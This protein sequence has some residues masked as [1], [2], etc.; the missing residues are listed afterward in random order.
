LPPDG[1]DFDVRGTTCVVVSDILFAGM[2]IHAA[3][4]VILRHG[5]PQRIQLAVLCDRG[6][7]ELPIRPDYVGKNFPM[8]VD[9]VLTVTLV[10]QE[11]YD[12]VFLDEPPSIG[13][14]STSPAQ[15]RRAP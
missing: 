9:D 7:R 10:E 6:H 11:G 14:N 12:G 15:R 4:D 1:I 2:S 5:R 13:A 3:M 8:S